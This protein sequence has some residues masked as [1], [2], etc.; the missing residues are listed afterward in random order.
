MFTKVLV[1][2]SDG[3][4]VIRVSVV[5]VTVFPSASF[6]SSLISLTKIVP[7]TLLALTRALF[8]TP[9]LSRAF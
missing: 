9:P 2:L 1:R 4:G 6:P 8:R 3:F 5:S 7:A